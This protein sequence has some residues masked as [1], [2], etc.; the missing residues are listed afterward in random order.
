MNKRLLP[1]NALFPIYVFLLVSLYVPSVEAQ[2]DPLAEAELV[3]RAHCMSCHG[4]RLEGGLGP[5]LQQVGSR[6]TKQAIIHKIVF[7]SGQMPAFGNQ[8]S[9]ATIQLLGEWL[10]RQQ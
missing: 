4:T 8:L 7:G 2:Q 1:W 3:Y 9:A 10:S 5:S 6:L